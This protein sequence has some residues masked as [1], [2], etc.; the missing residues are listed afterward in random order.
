MHHLPC[1]A[2]IDCIIPVFLRAVCR[3]L[4]S[5]FMHL[6]HTAMTIGMSGGAGEHGPVRISSH[7]ICIPVW[8]SCIM[9]TV[10]N[11]FIRRF[12]IQRWLYRLLVVIY[13]EETIVVRTEAVFTTR[14]IEVITPVP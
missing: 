12:A 9:Q 6:H 11:Q 8:F 4:I 13:V 1:A 2:V 3:F 14:S 7:I 10:W 5:W